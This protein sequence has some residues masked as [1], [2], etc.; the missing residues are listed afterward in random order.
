MTVAFEEAQSSWQSHVKST[1][2]RRIHENVRGK[3]MAYDVTGH[4]PV[5]DGTLILGLTSNSGKA[6][7]SAIRV[8]T[9]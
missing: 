2:V 4:V 7:V 6:L 3:D 1:V 5:S 9:A 8:T